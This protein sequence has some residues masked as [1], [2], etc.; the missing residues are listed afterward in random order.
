MMRQRRMVVPMFVPANCDAKSATY[1]A[2]EELTA[3]THITE[4]HRDKSHATYCT[5]DAGP[6]YPVVPAVCKDLERLI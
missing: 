1:R 2:L 3:R 4:D 5:D 6:I